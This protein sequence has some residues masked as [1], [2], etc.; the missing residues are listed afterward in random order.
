MNTNGYSNCIATL[1]TVYRYFG[2]FPAFP[3]T[4][5]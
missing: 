1:F 2:T 4:R 3:D 5:A